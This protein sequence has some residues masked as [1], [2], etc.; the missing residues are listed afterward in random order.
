MA[1]PGVQALHEEFGEKGLVVIGVN[2]WDDPVAAMVYMK[3]QGYTYTTV[4]NGDDVAQQYQVSGIPTFYV[5]GPDGRVVHH[6]VG[7]Q[8]GGHEA[9]KEI[10]QGLLPEGG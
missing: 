3:E 8:P 2:C 10:I 6:V 9:L 7:N 5:I 1:M 4:L